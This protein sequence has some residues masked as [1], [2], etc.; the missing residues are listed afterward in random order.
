MRSDIA[1]GPRETGDG[2]R[3]VIDGHGIDFVISP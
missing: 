3:R 1:M 2:L